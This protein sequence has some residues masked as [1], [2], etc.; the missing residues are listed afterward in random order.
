MIQEKPESH[1]QRE[2]KTLDMSRL[3]DAI[4]VET[5]TVQRNTDTIFGS[6][7]Q[8][9]TKDSSTNDLSMLPMD[10]I[11][12]HTDD[13]SNTATDVRRWLQL[14]HETSEL[15]QNL[16][17]QLR[18]I[19]EAAKATRFKGDYKSGKRINMRKVIPF[20]ASNYRK[21]K[22]W[23]RRTKPSKRDY[24]I[25]LAID[26]STSMRINNVNHIVDK[27]VVILCQTL[28]SLE[29]GKLGV[30]K[31]GQTSQIVQHLQVCT[32]FVFFKKYF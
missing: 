12:K 32:G 11:S 29:V 20:I 10:D 31:F 1:E 23:L 3:K 26:D 19:L 30:I 17:E 22:I 21:D 4:T 28:S 6:S 9:V 14:C 5:L 8:V 18:L 7:Q 27:S 15:I 16:T 24:N 25:I 2:G 13:S